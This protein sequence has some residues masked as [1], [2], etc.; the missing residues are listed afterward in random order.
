MSDNSVPGFGVLIA[1]LLSLALY[2]WASA[3]LAAVFGKLGEPGWKAWVPVY[4]SFV[5]FRLGGVAPFWAITLFLPLINVVGF[6]FSIFA[7]N[8]ISKQFDKGAGFTV[9]GV[10]LMPIWS[11]ILGWGRATAEPAGAQRVAHP[12]DAAP[13]AASPFGITPGDAVP[14]RIP[15]GEPVQ[16][17]APRIPAP[18]AAVATVAPADDVVQEAHTAPPVFS[19]T[20]AVIATPAPVAPPAPIEMPEEL[21]V[22]VE[23]QTAAPARVTPLI[24]SVPDFSAPAAPVAAAA[25][26]VVLDEPREAAAAQ[27]IDD[28]DDMDATVIAGR[29]NKAWVFETESGQRVPLSAE[30]VLLGRNPVPLAEHPDAQLITVRDAGRT[31][32]KTHASVQLHGTA[33]VITDLQSTNGV[34]VLDAEGAEIE[35]EPGVATE[36][37]GRFVLG[38][39]SARIF[40]E[41]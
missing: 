13:A 36:V 28:D 35:L 22:R 10:L 19:Y 2:V 26:S 40:Q 21:S 11:S 8:S 31:V 41:E 17:A 30:L 6:V 15:F 4:N 5:L 14:A 32:S 24:D 29:R 38:E 23:Q 18:A 27:P 20:P 25:A 34:Y 1:L 7:I 12:D 16:P 37:T 9:L 3:A 39:L 33:W